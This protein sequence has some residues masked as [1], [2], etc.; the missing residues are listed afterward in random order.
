M[1]L[2]RISTTY[3]VQIQRV[4][5]EEIIQKFFQRGRKVFEFL[6]NSSAKEYLWMSLELCCPVFLNVF[7]VIRALLT[8][9]YIH[10]VLCI[11]KVP[12]SRFFCSICKVDGE[13]IRV[14]QKGS[15][16]DSDSN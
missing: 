6:S 5:I 4:G 8:S 10:P 9:G 12:S 3:E 13:K 11:Y 16:E 2:V 7:P 14:F 15:P 1:Y